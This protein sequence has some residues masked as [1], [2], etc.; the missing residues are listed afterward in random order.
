MARHS[1][2][3]ARHQRA[4]VGDSPGV[5]N[6]D[7]QIGGRTFGTAIDGALASLA[8]RQH[9][10]VSRA[11]LLEL[12]LGSRRVEHRIESSRLH[13]IHRGVYAVGHRSLTAHG[14]WLAAVLAVGPDAV[15]SHR[16]AA[17]L[18]GLRTAGGPRVDVSVPALARRQRPRIAVHVTRELLERDRT[19]HTGIPVTSVARTLL[20]L[21]EVTSGRQLSRAFE[22]ADRARLL[23]LSAVEDVCTRAQGRR[24]LGALRRV[25]ADHTDPAPATRSELE[26]LF[27]DLCR[28]QGL[29]PPR[30][31]HL[32][33]GFEVDAVWPR[34]RLVVELDGYAY[35]RSRSAFERDR[36]QTP[37][38]WRLATASCGSPRAAC[39]GGR[40]RSS[41]PCASSWAS[42][43]N[44]NACASYWASRQNPNAAQSPR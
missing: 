8:E 40:P 11:Q 29:P 4:F 9:G 10:V 35:H 15:L 30:V 24:G 18:W 3:L 6:V 36:I 23:Y 43:R 28:E 44:P 16:S 33:A 42:S 22:E 20:D 2:R 17:A 19:Q 34:R 41:Q 31:N 13:P 21:A 39:K 27:G 1:R 5:P 14:F 37:H 38:S 12:G 7:R 32:I 25:V 26:R